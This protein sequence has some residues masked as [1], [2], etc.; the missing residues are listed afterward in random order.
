MGARI[1]F[2]PTHS[3]PNSGIRIQGISP[4]GHGRV[5]ALFLILFPVAATERGRGPDPS[6]YARLGFLEAVPAPCVAVCA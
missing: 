5:A 4:F 2:A 1:C 3:R 6:A